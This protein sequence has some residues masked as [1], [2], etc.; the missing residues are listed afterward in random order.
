MSGAINPQQVGV[1][2]DR[3]NTVVRSSDSPTERI[4]GSEVVPATESVLASSTPP[5]VK[6]LLPS[7]VVIVPT[8]NTK[9]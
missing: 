1:I 8:L 3:L 7:V 4:F 9:T 5:P 6:L 2:E